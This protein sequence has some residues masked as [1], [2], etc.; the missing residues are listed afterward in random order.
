MAI[1]A[2][3]AVTGALPSLPTMPTTQT[4]AVADPS[5]SFGSMLGNAMDG[6]QA[7]QSKADDLAVQAVTGQLTDVHD[8]MIASTEASL[9]TDLTVSVRNKAVEAFNSIMTM[10]F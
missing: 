3:G 2:I 10:Q 8:Y 5:A 1:P 4:A 6:L 7:T 9:A